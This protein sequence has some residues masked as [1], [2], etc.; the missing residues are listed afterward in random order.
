H[1]IA[2]S[3]SGVL[4]SRQ[5]SATGR[6]SRASYPDPEPTAV[7]AVG[8]LDSDDWR[9]RDHQLPRWV[10]ETGEAIFGWPFLPDALYA[11]QGSR[12]QFAGERDYSTLLRSYDEQG[13]KPVRYPQPG[14]SQCD[15]RVARGPGKA[16]P[17]FEGNSQPGFRELADQY[18]CQ[19]AQ[20]FSLFCD[21]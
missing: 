10:C 14:R 1:R 8:Q 15:L 17:V 19:S 12:L 2:R 18:D 3:P 13:E 21:C 20:R 7:P 16:I 5:P 11:W 4:Q 6:E 9:R